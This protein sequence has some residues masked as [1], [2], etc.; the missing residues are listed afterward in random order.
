M[1]PDMQRPPAEQTG[2]RMRSW[3]GADPTA[4][5]ETPARGDAP[6]ADPRQPTL[7]DVLEDGRRE[8]DAGIAAA[9]HA[10]SF[11][12]R[13]AVD[14]AIQACAASGDPFTAETVRARLTPGDRG[15]AVAHPNALGGR[16]L[17]AANRG[18]IEGHGWTTATRKAA[19]G[20]GIRVWRGVRH[21]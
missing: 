19:H 1:R 11:V 6:Y 17:A 9:D 14:D 7:D 16:F 20:R 5:S 10:A 2:G 8:R 21:G 3:Q 18:V 15:V 4:R 12:W 13:A